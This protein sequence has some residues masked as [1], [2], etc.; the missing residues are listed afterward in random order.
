MIKMKEKIKSA[1]LP[2]CE[3]VFDYLPQENVTYP[4]I[5][6]MEEENC[7]NEWTDDL[8]QDS[9]V[10]YRI[11]LYCSDNAEEMCMAID[12]QLAGVHGLKRIHCQDL[13]E[14]AKVKHKMLRYEAIIAMTSDDNIMVYH[15]YEGE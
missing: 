8:E 5:T 14:D 2:I 6:Y 12:E 10:K 15:K 7:V 1:L 4:L 13:N 3:N 9:Y 11:D